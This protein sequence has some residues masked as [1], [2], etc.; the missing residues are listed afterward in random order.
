MGIEAM[1]ADEE[2][3]AFKK[4]LINLSKMSLLIPNSCFSV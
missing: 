1:Q 4:E 2:D 3:W